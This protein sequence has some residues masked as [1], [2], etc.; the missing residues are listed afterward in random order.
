MADDEVTD[1]MTGM[2]IPSDPPADAPP[3]G[4]GTKSLPAGRYWVTAF[5]PKQDI[6]NAF[7]TMH[8]PVYKG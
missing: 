6:L 5:G 7:F 4:V 2:V 3:A 8:E 1:P